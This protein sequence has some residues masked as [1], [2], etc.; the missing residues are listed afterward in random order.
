MSPSTAAA[1][2]GR[3]PSPNRS[4]ASR[5]AGEA[6]CG[7]TL[8]SVSSLICPPWPRLLGVGVGR[9]ERGVA[10]RLDAHRRRGSQ[11]DPEEDR[12]ADVALGAAYDRAAL[13]DL[14]RG[15]GVRDLS[16][17]EVADLLEVLGVHHGAVVGRLRALAGVAEGVRGGGVVEEAPAVALR[18]VE[19]EGAVVA[20]VLAAVVVEVVRRV[21]GGD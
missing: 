21:V 12:V 7:A 3:K 4:S 14:L 1:T 13:L 8:P 2:A 18:G 20:E 19:L 5:S 6:R 11:R 17:Q 15:R 10:A 16:A 9:R